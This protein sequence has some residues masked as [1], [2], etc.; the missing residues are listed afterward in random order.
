[1]PSTCPNA[2]PSASG[3]SRA[4]TAARARRDLTGRKSTPVASGRLLRGRHTEIAPV[5][6]ALPRHG[7]V[8]DDAVGEEGPR[9]PRGGSDPNVA[10]PDAKGREC[11]VQLLPVE[12]GGYKGERPSPPGDT[13][14]PV[15][16]FQ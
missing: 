12:R 16:E 4:K 2:P 10:I 7:A 9:I 6:R 5:A 14:V 1:M 13:G 8:V 11:R 3:A 15:E